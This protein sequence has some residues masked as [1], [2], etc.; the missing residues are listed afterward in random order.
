MKQFLSG[1]WRST[2]AAINWRVI[3]ISTIVILIAVIAEDHRSCLRQVPVRKEETVRE[4]ILKDFLANASQSR[5]EIAQEEFKDH[6]P[7]RGNIDFQA[8]L[9]YKELHDR[10]GHLSI[11]NCNAIIP[12]D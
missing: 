11:P 7:I 9:H 6:Q 1:I 8:A 12:D 2:R 10:I 4:Q 5:L 3:T